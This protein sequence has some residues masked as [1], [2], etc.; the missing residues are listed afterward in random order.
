MKRKRVY[1]DDADGVASKIRE[2][3]LLLAWTIVKKPPIVAKD[4]CRSEEG[5]TLDL[6]KSVA[7]AGMFPS[8]K[9]HGSGRC[10]ERQFVDPVS[11]YRDTR[12]RAGP[13]G[14]LLENFC[15][16]VRVWI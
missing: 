15:T 8:C 11:S 12:T 16:L 3:R 2:R 13:S 1:A 9:A 14:D 6:E 10:I 4:V 5:V 7:G